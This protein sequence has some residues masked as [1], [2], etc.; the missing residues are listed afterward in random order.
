MLAEGLFIASLWRRELP[1]NLDLLTEHKD[2][3]KAEKRESLH[4][5]DWG[6]FLLFIF[7][8]KKPQNSSVMCYLNYK[9][10]FKNLL[11]CIT[12]PLPL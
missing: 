5:R 6:R 3:F 7:H 2:T 11:L 12:L 10:A 1:L 8:L 9:D 4:N